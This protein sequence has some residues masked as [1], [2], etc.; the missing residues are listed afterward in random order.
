M[1]GSFIELVNLLVLYFTSRPGPERHIN[2]AKN[3]V[4]HN[5]QI[6]SRKEIQQSKPL[7]SLS[8]TSLHNTKWR[9]EKK[10]GWKPLSSKKQ[11]NSGFSGK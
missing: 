9:D 1:V 6:K 2:I 10:K 11:F 5:T 4:S 3:Q 8:K 7:T